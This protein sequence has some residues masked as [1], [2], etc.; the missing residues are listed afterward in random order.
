MDHLFLGS[1]AH[2][3]SLNEFETI[4]NGFLAVK[5]GKIVAIGDRSALPNEYLTTLP[6]TTLTSSQ[7]LLPGFVDCHIHAPQV[8]SSRPFH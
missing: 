6:V 2:S 4:E 5:N 7:F 8:C 1:I 3:K